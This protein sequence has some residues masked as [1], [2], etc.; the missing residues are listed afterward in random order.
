M[1]QRGYT[2]EMIAEALGITKQAVNLSLSSDNPRMESLER[3]A[4]LLDVPLYQ[5]FVDPDDLV[6]ADGPSVAIECPHC[7]AKLEAVLPVSI[8]KAY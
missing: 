2:Q 8:K 5:L 6:R 3:I 1:R 4:R 7:G